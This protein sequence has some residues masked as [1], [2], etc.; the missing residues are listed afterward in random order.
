MARLLDSSRSSLDYKKYNKEDGT[1]MGYSLAA[2]SH[3]FLKEPKISMKELFAKPSLKLDGTESKKLVL[4][5]VRDLQTNKDTIEDWIKYSVRDAQNTYELFQYLKKRLNSMSWK[6]KLTMYDLYL[7]YLRP[8]GEILTDMECRGFQVAAPET[9]K[10]IEIIA[11]QERNKHLKIFSSWLESIDVFND[12]KDASRF[13]VNS[14]KQKQALFFGV[15]GKIEAEKNK[16]ANLK[17][18]LVRAQGAQKTNIQNKLNKLNDVDAVFKIDNIEGYVTKKTLKSGK[19]KETVL[20]QREMKIKGLGLKASEYTKTGFP[21]S[22][23]STLS[24]LLSS[25]EESIDRKLSPEDDVFGLNKV[26]LNKVK[27]LEGIKALKEVNTIDKML[28]SFIRPLPKMTD[29][30]GR[31]HCA[32]NLNTETGRLSARRPNL[33]NQP[34]L[35]KDIYKIREAFIAKEDHTLIVADYGQL[36]LRIL[37]DISNCKSMKEAFIKGGDFHSRTAMGMFPY[38]REALKRG[39]VLL[40]KPLEGKSGDFKLLKDVYAAERRQA[41]ALNFSIAYGKTSF[42]LAKDFKVTKEEA[43]EILE[44]WYA[45][46]PE[47]RNWQRATIEFAKAKGYVE[48]MLGRRRKLL[49]INSDDRTE[50]G[51]MERAAINTPIQGSAA[52]VVLCSMVKI[53]EDDWL[54]EK[55]WRMILQV[56]DEIILE[57]P[58]DDNVSEALERVKMLMKFPFD[59]ESIP[60]NQR[61]SMDVELTVDANIGQSWYEAK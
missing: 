48:T 11:E 31:I 34:A 17:R 37:A 8:F 6:K 23:G 14:S 7:S 56:H 3:D 53:N 9:L 41:K 1:S 55:G 32:L 49:G 59:I 40:E 38:I 30:E 16:I 39:E 46:R 33:Q 28:S 15:D 47:V 36:E 27:A 5:T 4:P 24:A 61:V 57:G 10:E 25:L 20:K 50:S 13:N 2:L 58:K 60:T 52:D 35:E 44:R 51:H 26:K 18:Q 43:E 29:D 19:I 21:S 42:G 54:R 22:S 12:S 45:D